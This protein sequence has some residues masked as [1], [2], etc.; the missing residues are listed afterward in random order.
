MGSNLAAQSA[1]G[2]TAA[3]VFVHAWLPEVGPL[4]SPLLPHEAA[5]MQVASFAGYHTVAIL[6]RF[7]SDGARSM[8]GHNNRLGRRDARDSALQHH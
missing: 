2:N 7:Q 1:A 4:P 8:P 6:E 3:A 5:L